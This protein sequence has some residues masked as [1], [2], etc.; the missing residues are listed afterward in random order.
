MRTSEALRQGVHPETLYA[1]RDAHLVEQ[2]VPG[3]FKLVDVSEDEHLDWLIVAK[4]APKAVI[5]LTSALAFHDLT[6]HLT[7][8]TYIMLPKGIKP[9]KAERP[10][11]RS[12]HQAQPSYEAGIQTHLI[13]QIPV[14]IYSPE[15]TVVDCFQFRS[16]VG[17]EVAI[18]A[19]KNCVRKR[20]RRPIHF[21]EFA[22]LSG[23]ENVM[24]PYLEAI[25]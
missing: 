9:P 24:R 7:E 25:S 21:V 22:R 18:D 5:C 20:K 14:R 1:M 11:I 17:L 23:V 6:D 8:D 2:I 10:P 15:K 13:H 16:R 12:F 3:L 19:L 4:R